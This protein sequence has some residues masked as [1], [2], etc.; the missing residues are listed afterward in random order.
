MELTGKQL[1][2]QLV[3]FRDKMKE[4]QNICKNIWRA[5]NNHHNNESEKLF[6]EEEPLREELVEMWGR[7]E[8]FFE[9]MRISTIGTVYGR[10]FCIF[11][12]ALDSI[13]Y[14][15]PTKGES[16]SM[17]VQASIKAVG[18]ADSFKEQELVEDIKFHPR[19]KA[20][21]IKLLND[22]HYS[23][24]VE[25]S[26]KIVKDRLRELTGYE[27]GADA[28]GKTKLHIKGASAE[29]VDEDFNEGVRFLCM[30]VDKFR[31]EKAHFADAKIINPDRAMAYLYIS[32]LVMFFLDEA[33]IKPL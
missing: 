9:K 32:N 30:A 11:D 4:Y 6:K 3:I 13:F 26:F 12:Q 33:E 24:A 19:I 10:Q 31:N 1:K 28:F 16:L 7:L 18:V 21:C 15:N 22:A 17:A 29:H 25:K 20:G 23:E 2:K 5:M 8:R 14:N 27:K